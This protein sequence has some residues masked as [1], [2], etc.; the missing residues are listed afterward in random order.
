MVLAGRTEAFEHSAFVPAA[1]A[2]EAAL[3]RCE[4]YLIA[5]EGE[6]TWWVGGPAAGDLLPFFPSPNGTERIALMNANGW[7]SPPGSYGHDGSY[8]RDFDLVTWEVLACDT[9]ARLG[10]CVL[11][12]TDDYCLFPE[13]E[14]EY[15]LEKHL[16][17]ILPGP[18]GADSP[19]ELSTV[20]N[21]DVADGV[22]IFRLD[23]TLPAAESPNPGDWDVFEVP[24]LV[25]LSVR[26]IREWFY[27]QEIPYPN[28]HEGWVLRHRLSDLLLVSISAKAAD[29]RALHLWG[30]FPVTETIAYP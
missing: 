15:G 6:E 9:V 18:A 1:S 20:Y 24:D 25:S 21:P 12:R 27:Y 8:Q 11:P 2:D 5:A 7:L 28:S 13:P 22:T 19:Y 4:P 14:H 29:D 30:Y 16:V 26:E 23:I 3:D 10:H 17:R